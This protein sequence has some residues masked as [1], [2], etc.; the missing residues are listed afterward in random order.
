M[1][2]SEKAKYLR[3]SAELTQQELSKNLGITASAIGYLE[4]GK[5]E[6]TGSTLIAYAKF[7][8]ISIDELT[9]IVPSIEDSIIQTRSP[10][11]TLTQEERHLVEDYRALAPDLQEMIRATIATW[12]S[13]EANEERKKKKGGF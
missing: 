7:F 1:K 5:R 8:D 2:F 10:G 11:E 3:I 9:G 6:P 13:S 12:K 4:N